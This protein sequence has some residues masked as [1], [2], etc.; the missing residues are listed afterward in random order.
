MAEERRS[1]ATRCRL[2]DVRLTRGFGQQQLADR[3]GVTRQSIGAIEGGRYVPNTGVALALARALGCRVEDLFALPAEEPAALPVALAAPGAGTPGA[4]TPAGRRVAIAAVRGRL[5]AHALG[6]AGEIQAAFLPADGVL[7]G[8]GS[9]SS[10]AQLLATPTELERSALVLGCDPG[11]GIAA[12][13]VERRNPDARLRCLP[14]ASR[15]ALARL[16]AGEAHVAGAHLHAPGSA[17][18]NL[19]QARRA[20]AATGGL[21]VR[22]ASWEQGLAVASGNPLRIR[23]ATDLARPRVRIVNRDPG[24]GARALLDDR[25]RREGVDPAHVRGYD[26]VVAT[27][28]AA[29]ACVA[30]GGADAAISLRATARAFGLDFVP[31]EV[32]DFDLAIPADHADHPAVATLLD[33]L[34]GTALRRE[35]SE[36]AGYDV[37]RTGIIVAEIP[38]P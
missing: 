34:A 8:T 11:L 32:S 17:L 31:V 27:H 38:A 24:S 13:H 2:R 1:P 20:L 26:R 21:L 6:T 19:P 22:F 7:S 14:I 16:R 35:L 10:A 18:Q 9:R 28:V 5:V 12:A 3:C 23:T 33:V 29:A 4:P 30:A 36:L 15:E 37:S 25:L